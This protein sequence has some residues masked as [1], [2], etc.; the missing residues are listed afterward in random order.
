[1][2]CTSMRLTGTKTVAPVNHKF[3]CLVELHKDLLRNARKMPLLDR[4]GAPQANA[5]APPQIT[6]EQPQGKEEKM[7]TTLDRRKCRGRAQGEKT[8]IVEAE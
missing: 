6:L 3:I 7:G 2:Q 1:M 8:D 5:M 4:T